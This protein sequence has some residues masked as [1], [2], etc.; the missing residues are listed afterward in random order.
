MAYETAVDAAE[1]ATS[2]I[3][4]DLRRQIQEGT[5]GPGA[6]LPSEP[7]LARE[8]A[9]SRQTA[10]TALQTLERE[11]LVTVR[12]KRGRI[13]RIPP[14]PAIRSS[15]RHQEE[16]DRA[17]LPEGKRG[18]IG[19]AETNLG[20]SIADQRFTSAYDVINANDSLANALNVELGT[21]V[22]RRRFAATDPQTNRLLSTSVSYIPR[23]YVDNNPALLDEENEPWPGGT[24][25]Q[26]STVGIEIMR[27]VD[28]VTARMPTSSEAQAWDMPSGVP[29]LICRRISFDTNNRLIEVS[30]A[31]YPADRTELR[32]IT[33]LK[34]WPKPPERIR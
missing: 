10:R 12:A 27:V 7:E 19:E 34:P 6:L 15:D 13:V 11:G 9:V 32:F 16:K 2:K 31:E 18:A 17:V 21:P 8:Y 33:P 24:L 29:L 14:R 20:M 5:L 23:F 25:H 4:N 30:D 3:T 1:T 22:L 26:L 28:E